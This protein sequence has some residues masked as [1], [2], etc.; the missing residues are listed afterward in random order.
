MVEAS[1]YHAE[2][3]ETLNRRAGGELDVTAIAPQPTGSRLYRIMSPA[4]SAPLPD[5]AR[6]TTLATRSGRVSRC[7][8]RTTLPPPASFLAFFTDDGLRRQWADRARPTGVIIHE[9]SSGEQR[10]HRVLDL[11]EAWT[12]TGLPILSAA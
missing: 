8:E 10:T 2:D 4:S 9:V 7:R 11:G 12:A 5:R 1:R 6:A 3:V